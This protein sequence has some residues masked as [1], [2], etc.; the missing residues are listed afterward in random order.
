MSPSPCSCL[1]PPFQEEYRKRRT[2]QKSIL[3]TTWQ[4][5]GPQEEDTAHF[6]EIPS[7]C[8][9]AC[10]CP[11]SLT[12]ESE[13]AWCQREGQAHC[14]HP[15]TV[16]TTRSGQ[17]TQ[18]GLDSASRRG[19]EPDQGRPTHWEGPGFPSLIPQRYPGGG[20]FL[21]CFPA[22]GHG[23]GSVRASAGGPAGTPASFSVWA[24]L[25]GQLLPCG[26]SHHRC[27]V[28]SPV[29]GTW[30]RGSLC[31]K[32]FWGVLLIFF[33]FLSCFFAL[34]TISYAKLRYG[35]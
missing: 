10:L 28:T 19:V 23:Q 32:E 30:E 1:R 34:K 12:K 24:L 8:R 11:F 15:P 21:I 5:G 18:A 35:A 4:L 7:L 17:D 9:R 33:L 20:G 6:S 3:P 31:A 2:R 22:R 27:A 14:C 25:R 16:T 26:C 13:S 29:M